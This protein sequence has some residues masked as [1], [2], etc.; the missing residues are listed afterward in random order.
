[1]VALLVVACAETPP[2]PWVEEDGYRW[3][4]VFPEGEGGFESVGAGGRGIDFVYDV[5]EDDRY[6]NRIRVE[7]AGVAIGDVDADGLADLFF[8][9]FGVDSRLYRN[10]GRWRFD[11]IT[12]TAG[13]A[14]SGVLVR[15]A[16]LADLDG[17]GDLDLVATVH[18]ASNRIFLNDGTGV[19]TPSAQPAMA[20]ERGS[21]TPSLAD[22]DGDG[23]LD[24]Y[25][26]N[27]K[28]LQA[29]DALSDIERSG[30]SRLRPGPDG[31]ITV[32]P[33][34]AEHYR[35]EFDGRFVRW[36]ELGEVDELYL[37][38]GRGGFAATTLSARLRA[39]SGPASADSLRDW[40]LAGRFSDWDGDGDPDLYVANDFNSPDGIWLNRGDGTFDAAPA[41]DIRST[42]LSSMAVEVADLERDGDLDIVTTDMLARDPGMRLRQVPSFS[43]PAEP[44]GTVLTRLQLNRNAVQLNRGDGTF[45]EVAAATG[46]DASDWT[47]GA[48]FLDADLDGYED[49]LVTTGHVWDQ[50]D[51]DAGERLSRAPPGTTDWRRHLSLFP[52]L[53][54]PNVAF[55][56]TGDGTFEDVSDAWAWS[57]GPDVSHGIA[58]GDLDAD[59]D[60][61]VVVTR[62]GQPP[63]LM[64]NESAGGRVLVRLEGPGG[65]TRGVGGRVKASGHPAGEQIDEIVAGGSYLSSSESAA[66]FA[67]PADGM[68]TVT[69]DWPGGARSIV[70]G[71]AANL[72][73]VIRH[74]GDTVASPP[75]TA[76]TTAPLFEDV[77]SLLQHRHV[78]TDFDDRARQ[79][80]LPIPLS[81]LGPGVSWLDVDADRDPDLLIG[82]GRGGAPVVLRN[83]GGRFDTPRALSPAL[84]YDASGLLGH[85]GSDGGLDLLVGVSN[86]EAPN[87]RAGMTQPS[88]I[89]LRIG[90]A[91]T[92]GPA[93]VLEGSNAA[94]G[95]LAQADID[96]DGDL[97]LFVGGRAVPTRVPEAADSR[98]MRNDEGVLVFDARASASFR[99]I[100]LVSGAVFSDLDGD[101]DPDLAL[102]VSWGSVRVFRND[103]GRL[104]DATDAYGLTDTVGRWNAI[105]AGD[106]DED[107]A[108]D[109]VL[110]AWGDNTELPGTYSLFHGDLDRNGQYDA[111]EVVRADDGWRPI[112]RR[113]ELQIGIPGLA[114]L[115][116]A[117]FTETPLES[118][119]APAL[120]DAER[121]DVTD[122]RHTVF[123]NRGD[124]FEARPLLVEAQRAPSLGAVVADFDGDGHEDLF[125]SQNF[126]G[127]RP[128]VPR[129]DAGRGL[130]LVGDGR[131]GFDAQS[132]IETGIAVYGDARA[133]AA[134]DFDGDR[135]PDLVVGVNGDRTRL[136]RNALGRP[137][138]RVELSGPA[139]NPDAIGAVV[140]VL[141][142]DG[143]TGP[144]REVRS[145]EGYWSRN[146]SVQTLGLRSRPVAVR[147]VWP[148]GGVTEHPVTAD[149]TVLEISRPPG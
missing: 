136:F 22:I 100:G 95:P 56:A 98:I 10:L 104:V 126:F 4:E 40:G 63:L 60:L 142:E 137:G 145:G 25:I 42:S 15:G 7:G 88:V 5:S 122:L 116:F 85:V 93:E 26:A 84:P 108:Q 106:F 19:F 123:M 105:T 8:A 140:T 69:V 117:A 51:A 49:L 53:S 24:L 119:L 35:V 52:S 128:G 11:D 3:R 43:Q 45:A 111:L 48:L 34:L 44:P 12:E 149:Q 87:P 102:A 58:A 38:D 59:G 78:E 67:A 36:W 61:D 130:L 97:D 129:Y 135:R 57:A 6:A 125:L 71:L 31:R 96:G 72:E 27:Y 16:A 75:E 62:L 55:R 29:D 124:R 39:A 147:V 17:D 46:L 112:R 68:L 64:R 139:A 90:R 65:N 20:V 50:L 86:Y 70:P 66:V 131:G 76:E 77:S 115:P 132:G 54:Q 47:W 99:G 41:T 74:P 146:E 14:L 32:P 73:V 109:L 103:N 118:L 91:G 28:T 92:G 144:S 21:T 138:L 2:G 141:Y 23:D 143:S 114:R 79:P 30:L 127:V 121:V 110:T 113:D 83:D 133:A 107:G 33:Q 82:T 80:L 18:G 89:G 9:G 81:R 101:G 120:D 148:G 1:M 134:A 13:A 37:N 94:T